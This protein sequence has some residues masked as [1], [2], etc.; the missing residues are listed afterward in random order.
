LTPSRRRSRL[1]SKEAVSEAAEAVGLVEPRVAGVQ[2]M[3]RRVVD[4]HQNHVTAVRGVG[5]ETRALCDRDP[6]ADRRP[7]RA[8]QRDQ[9]A[10]V[11]SRCKSVMH[12]EAA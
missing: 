3:A 5:A 7:R 9:R 12:P 10:R 8:L 2:E 1:R 11:V 6:E 4:V